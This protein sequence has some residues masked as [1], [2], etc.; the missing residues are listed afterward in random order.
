MLNVIFHLKVNTLIDIYT[1]LD[2]SITKL[3][4]HNVKIR[5]AILLLLFTSVLRPIQYSM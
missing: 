3:K 5:F 2:R 4:H 1:N